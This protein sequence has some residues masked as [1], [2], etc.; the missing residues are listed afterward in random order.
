VG[1]LEIG[2]AEGLAVELETLP[3]DMQGSLRV[4]LLRKSCIRR[5]SRASPWRARISLQSLG[6]VASMK[7]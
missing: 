4:E 3:E 6:W 5:G 7:E 2:E 1:R